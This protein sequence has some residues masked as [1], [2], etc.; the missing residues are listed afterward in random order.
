M[1][2][3]LRIL[4]VDDERDM[5]HS[6]SQW[7]TL[8]GYEAEAVSSGE[9]ALA[10]I[11]ADFAGIVVSDIKM[12]HMDGVTLLKRIQALDGQLPVILI[13]GHGDVPLAVEAMR[14][15][16]YDFVEKPFQPAALSKIVKKALQ[17]RRLQLENRQ[18][19]RDLTSADKMVSR[20]IGRSDKLGKH[21]EAI[22]DC[23]HSDVP[24]L[25][26]GETGV[27]KTLSAHAIHASSS[28]AGKPFVELRCAAYG[29]NELM[30]RLFGEDPSADGGAWREAM[31]G[32]LVLEDIETLPETTQARLL[33]A[34]QVGD[35][36]LSPRVIGVVNAE[37]GMESVKSALRS[38]LFFQI[39]GH[40]LCVPPLR[41]REDDV[42]QVFQHYCNEFASD[43][44]CAAPVLNVD[45][46]AKMM[47]A[48][49]PG[50]IRQVIHL[51]EHYVL[52][53]RR[54]D[55]AA[56]S[57]LLL[58]GQED[59]NQATLTTD[60]RPLRDVVDSFEK[61]IIDA[62]MRKHNGM[63]A[64]VMDELQ[65]PRRTLNEKMSKYG[66]QRSDYR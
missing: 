34:I 4:I 51:A 44:G 40:L 26:L 8:S 18:L 64:Q 24:C 29:E 66:L 60:G 33:S 54:E 13:T 65:L 47:K 46:A 45:D 17:K 16:A 58:N 23:G 59:H 39:S 11:D 50:N 20:L 63:I 30:A 7:L 25:I 19:R 28:R 1:S 41:E 10:R 53:S 14:S 62:A 3:V 9:E 36:Q 32:S 37:N 6:I 31:E 2:K 55:G 21:K 43:Y 22:L 12:P 5:R 27:G 57:S 38:D 49:W 48:P 42:L 35:P 15:G 52:Q 56:I 61:M